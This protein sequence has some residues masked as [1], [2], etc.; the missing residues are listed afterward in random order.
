MV[1]TKILRLLP[2]IGLAF[3]GLGVLYAAT[4]PT[5]TV[6][7]TANSYA[8]V[9]GETLTATVRIDVLESENCTVGM[10]LLTLN[11]TPTSVLTITSPSILGPP[12]PITPTFSLQATSVGTATLQAEF[13]S[14]LNCGFWIW[15][16]YSGESSTILVAN[17]LSKLYLPLMSR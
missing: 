13:L 7:V 12:V 14:E 2:A 8:V 10:Y 6:S 5:V 4:E 17:Q 11:S 15:K 1:F 16:D 3:L 9:P